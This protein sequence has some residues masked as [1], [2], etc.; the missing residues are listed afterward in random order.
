M[1]IFQ[2]KHFQNTRN[3]VTKVLDG[4]ES[5]FDTTQIR[6]KRGHFLLGFDYPLLVIETHKR[7]LIA[8]V[9]HFLSCL[10]ITIRQE[11]PHM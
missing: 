6:L 1:S 9:C 11:R 3:I 2:V 7:S 10:E 8:S 4:R 5:T